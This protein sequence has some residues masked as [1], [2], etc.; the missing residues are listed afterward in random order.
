MKNQGSHHESH[1]AKHS[2]AVS[3]LLAPQRPHNPQP[4]VPPRERA[5]EAHMHGPPQAHNRSHEA[6]TVT[7]ARTHTAAHTTTAT[8]ALP[9]RMCRRPMKVPLHDEGPAP[10]SKRTT[11]LMD[12]TVANAKPGAPAW[13][14]ALPCSL[15]LRC[16][17]VSLWKEQRV[18]RGDP[19]IR[20]SCARLRRVCVGVLGWL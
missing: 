11:H 4:Q 9:K 14:R 8:H 1:T 5:S 13:S 19:V 20:G 15:M 3:A 10:Q 6:H 16:V 7:S 12:R 17:V 18:M 2:Q